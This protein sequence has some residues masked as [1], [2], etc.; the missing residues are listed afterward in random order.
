MKAIVC[1]KY[2]TP[3]VL[4]LKNIETPIPKDNE[5]LVK[6]HATTVNRTDCAILSAKPFIMR[7]FIGLLKPKKSILGT[8]FA[9]RIE[10]IGKDVKSYNV[11]DN[12]FGF[13]DLV[14]SSHAEYITIAEHKDFTTIPEN[15]TYGHAVSAVE[16]VH[17]AYN[18]INK[19]DIRSGQKI[20]V[21]GA[22][23]AIGSAMVQLL[24]EFNVEITAVCNTK[25]L[26]LVKSLGATHII[27]Y[28]KEDFTKMD[29]KFD[30]VFDAVGKSSFSKCKPLLKS[31]GIYMSSELGQMSQNIYYAL[32]TPLFG[33]KKVVFPF[34]SR[35][36]ASLLFV[37]TL[38]EHGK[39]QAVID[40]KFPL[41]K[42][43]DA[44]RYVQK[45]EKT[46]NVVIMI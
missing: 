25:N 9:G 4:S 5:I 29:H 43:T 12:I 28:T 35:I 18:F 20:L 15:I 30:F 36:K 24:K 32:L 34:P 13:D 46:G 33:N 10:A 8:D 37:K 31:G 19:V 38:L 7:F 42:I 14:L 21:N 27:D 22:T 3:E 1:T 40:K 23:G 41:E 17:Y 45:G 39:F 2:G 6:V 16:G 44:Y 26:E 11:G